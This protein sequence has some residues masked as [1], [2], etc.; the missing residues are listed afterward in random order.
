[1]N[2]VR[3]ERCGGLARRQ[4][5]GTWICDACQ[6]GV[7]PPAPALTSKSDVL[8]WLR[9]TAADYV[10]GGEFSRNL[11]AAASFIESGAGETSVT[12]LPEYTSAIGDAGYEYLRSTMKGGPPVW[13]P[14]TFRWHEL[15]EAMCKAAGR[16]AETSAPH[17]TAVA[18][19]ELADS[20]EAQGFNDMIGFTPTALRRFADQIDAVRTAETSVPP[21]L[22]SWRLAWNRDCRCGCSA[23]AVFDLKLVNALKAGG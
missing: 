9:D 20:H 23:C 18:L 17:P 15:W 8:E 21:D 2:E 3:C 6:C 11:L 14:G 19:R 1:M 7:M 16:A 4:L 12:P 5:I 13:L 22:A 10:D